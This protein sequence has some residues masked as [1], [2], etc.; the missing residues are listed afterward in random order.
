MLCPREPV[1]LTIASPCV[2]SWTSHQLSAGDPVKFKTAGALPTGLVAGTTYYVIATGLTADVFRVSATLGGAAINTSGSQS[3]VHTAY[4]VPFGCAS[5]FSTF[6]LPDVRG[7]FVRGLD[8]GRGV[9][10][11]RVLGAAQAQDLQPHS[12]EYT[13]E[14]VSPVGT[15][16]DSG[17]ATYASGTSNTGAAGVTETRPRNVT[18]ISCIKY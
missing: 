1:T 2:I 13:G 4:H 3:G 17:S 14:H 7:E 18:K 12:H 16:S 9:D 10:V 5:D 6:N 11:S 15:G 8:N